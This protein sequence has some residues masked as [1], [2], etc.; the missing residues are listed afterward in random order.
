MPVLERKPFRAITLV[1]AL[2][3]SVMGYYLSA[4]GYLMPLEKGQPPPDLRYFNQ[5]KQ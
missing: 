3:L 5:A 2:G 1:A 4:D